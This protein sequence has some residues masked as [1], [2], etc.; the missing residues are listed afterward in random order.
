MKRSLTLVLLIY[1]A[2]GL[3]ASLAVH[4]LLYVGISL[5]EAA[6]EVWLAMQF[7]V[8]FGLIGALLLK[9]RFPKSLGDMT[10]P[11]LHTAI[12]VL[13]CF[14]FLYT[15]ANF[16]YCQ[17]KLKEGYPTTIDGQSVLFLY[18]GAPP[19]RLTAEQFRKAKLYQARKT[20]GHWMLVQLMALFALYQTY[21]WGKLD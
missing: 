15:P 10:A 7:G 12:V 18:H 14:F 16:F 4:F 19:E 9:P 11:K 8:F 17:V 20:S 3:L 2:I 13:T 21:K 5:Y 6:P 1:T